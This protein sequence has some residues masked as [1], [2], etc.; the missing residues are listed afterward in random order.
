M[1]ELLPCPFCG[2]EELYGPHFR[3]YCG[4]YYFP[5]WWVE[6]SNCPCGMETKGESVEILIDA[7]NRRDKP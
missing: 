7:W 6:C 4:D 5:E 2:S 1:T 3:E